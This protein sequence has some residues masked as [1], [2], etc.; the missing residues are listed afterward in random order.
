M[1]IPNQKQRSVQMHDFAMNPSSEVPRSQHDLSHGKKVPFSFSYL[2]PILNEFVLPGDTWNANITVAARTAV[3]IV[4]LQD[5]WRL[6]FFSFFIPMR[7]VWN[8]TARFFGEQDNPT[9][10]ISFT[11]PQMVSPTGGYAIGTLQDYMGLPTAGQIT[12][13]NTITHSSLPV[14]AYNLLKNTWFRDENIETSA[15]VGGATYNGASD[16]PDNW[17]S[18]VLQQRGKR[19]DYFTQALPWPQKGNVSIPL[20]LGTTAPIQSTGLGITFDNIS[21]GRAGTGINLTSGVNTPTWTNTTASATSV[22]T[23]G[24]AGLGQQSLVTNLAGATGTTLNAF[25]QAVTMQQYLE[26]DARGGT[27]YTEYNFNHYK[28]RSPDARLQRPEFI[29]GGS[30][31]INTTAIPQTS[32]TGL[33]GGT[34]PA[35]TLS[36]SGYATG[37]AGFTYSATEHGFI[38]TLVCATADLTYSQGMRRQWSMLTR[39]DVPVPLLMGLGEQTILTKEIYIDGSAS[40][41]T[42]FGYAPRWDEYRYI[43]SSIHGIYRPNATGNIAYWHSSQLFGSTP[44]LNSTFILDDAKTVVQR[45]FSAGAAT[46]GQQIL[47]DFYFDIKAARPISVYGIPGL[48]RL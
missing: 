45:N 23:F 41:N 2:I 16:G 32:A 19:F 29:G 30:A 33:S 40:D 11:I 15:F 38:I 44:T 46:V 22:A 12:A 24:A 14:R 48:T 7:L 26:K 42:A 8:N 36:A 43:P 34:T 39:Y 25:R 9:D 6:D 5:N 31:P 47:A 1:N 3:P 17:F 13:G 21:G 20:P 35:G 4:P 37:R 18:Y 10:S 27:R 28:V